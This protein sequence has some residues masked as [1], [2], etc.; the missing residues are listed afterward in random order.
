MLFCRD[1]PKQKRKPITRQKEKTVMIETEEEEPDTEIKTEGGEST[2][3]RIGVE[4]T[5]E[6]AELPRK[7]VDDVL[8]FNWMYDKQRFFSYWDVLL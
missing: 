4:L 2:D 8:Y 1:L 3:E 7:W 6:V 5:G